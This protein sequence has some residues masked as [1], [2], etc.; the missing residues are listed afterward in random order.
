MS[1]LYLPGPLAYPE[2]EKQS[3]M[4]RGTHPNSL[5]NLNRF[6]STNQPKNTGR[7]PSG[8]RKFFKENNV[9]REDA[10]IMIRNVLFGFTEEKL[11]ALEDDPKKPLV[12]RVFARAFRTDWEN[13]S[14]TNF[15][16]FMTWAYGAPKVDVNLT[17]GLD[18]TV[19][20]P[21]DRRTRID[22]LLAGLEFNR[23][24]TQ[25]EGAVDVDGQE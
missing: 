13:G 9:S 17:G 8:L 11:Q 1:M 7:K 2:S 5:A 3:R 4:Q 6:T 14:L 15:T 20:S 21:Q 24:P 23:Q 16:V 10:S 12:I 22:E 19:L 18:I 25:A